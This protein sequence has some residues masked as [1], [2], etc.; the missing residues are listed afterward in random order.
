LLAKLKIF[1]LTVVWLIHSLSH[2]A[3]QQA[4]VVK[5]DPSGVHAVGTHAHLGT[6]GFSHTVGT[7][8]IVDHGCEGEI[9]LPLRYNRAI[10]TGE[11]RTRTDCINSTK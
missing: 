4:M 11:N 8:W 3:H 5:E 7:P 10:Y 6:S 9:Q 2:L 1:L